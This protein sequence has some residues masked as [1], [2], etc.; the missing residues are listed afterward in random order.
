MGGGHPA[1]ID[2]GGGS[3]ESRRPLEQAAGAPGLGGSS[4][5]WGEFGTGA[6][7]GRLPEQ[8][9]GQIRPS[10]APQ[11][12]LTLPNYKKSS[13]LETKTPIHE[14]AWLPAAS[15]SLHP[16]SPPPLNPV[17]QAA[18]PPHLI[19]HPQIPLLSAAPPAQC[20]V[21]S[22]GVI[23][24]ELAT[25][26]MP[27]SGMNPMQVVGAVGFQDRRLEISSSVDPLVARIIWEC[28]QT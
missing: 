20:D 27:W 6:P 24:W 26:R 14:G 2:A 10:A 28:W 16:P 11:C 12:T 18:R 5:G 22:F 21:Y 1:G 9:A 8:A 23:F 3:A 13:G 4:A 19:R 25:L 17:R 15:D 7:F